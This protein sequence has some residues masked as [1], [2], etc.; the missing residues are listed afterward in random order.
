MEADIAQKEKKLKD[1][2]NDLTRK[3]NLN[4]NELL[5]LKDEIEKER[6]KSMADE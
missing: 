5:L 1:V 6:R 2:I 3:S 4:E